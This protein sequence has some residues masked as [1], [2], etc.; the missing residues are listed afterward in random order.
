M[1][2][3]FLDTS[4]LVKRYHSESGSHLVESLFH[5]TGN[6]ILVS[7]LALLEIHSSFARLV[8]ERTLT[9]TDFNE[10]IAR[11]TEDVAEGVLVITAVTSQRLDDAARILQTHGMTIAIR[12]LDAIHLAT[13]QAI[14]RRKPL[15]AFVAAD[16]RLLTDAGP[17]CG[18]PMM[19]V[20]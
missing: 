1:P 5:E 19:D 9:T 3:F 13:A 6:R 8:R 4:A 17:A 10:L 16:K 14:H 2:R 18:L 11:L 20:G 12:T 15:A 7:R